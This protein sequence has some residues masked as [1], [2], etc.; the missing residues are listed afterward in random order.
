MPAAWQ[1]AIDKLDRALDRQLGETV[2]IIPM[3]LADFGKNPDPARPA[4]DV[5]ALVDFLE[6]ASAQVQHTET[7]VVHE[8]VHVEVQ[9]SELAGRRV[10][11]NDEILLLD[12]PGSPRVVVNFVKTLDPGR[13]LFICGPAKD[14]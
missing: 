2:S 8:E 13:G 7:R 12:R 6:P 1:T 5:T 9:R 14:A 11:K 10:A 4:F 3:R